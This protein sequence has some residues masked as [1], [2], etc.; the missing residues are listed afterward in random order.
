MKAVQELHECALSYCFIGGRIAV[1]GLDM[2]LARFHK[3][4]VAGNIRILD[5]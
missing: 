1:T 4:V 3:S 5:S 2:M